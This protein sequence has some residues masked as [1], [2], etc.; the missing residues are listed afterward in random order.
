MVKRYDGHLLCPLG[1][2]TVRGYG[3]H[4]PGVFEFRVTSL[5]KGISNKALGLFSRRLGGDS[6]C[7]TASGDTHS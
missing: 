7:D 6:A 1:E 3:A 5:S 2:P 4:T